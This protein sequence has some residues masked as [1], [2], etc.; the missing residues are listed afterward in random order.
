MLRFYYVVV[1]FMVMTS[2]LIGVLWCIEKF[3]LPGR[4][5]LGAFYFRRLSGLLRVRVK[6]VGTPVTDKPVLILSN[7]VSWVDIPSIG[8][9]MPLVFISKSEVRKWPLV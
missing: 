9:I 6:V 1:C 8:S 5:A 4:R 7:H 3:G 2:V